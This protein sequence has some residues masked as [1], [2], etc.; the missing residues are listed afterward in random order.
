MVERRFLRELDS[1]PSVHDFVRDF[2]R[3]RGVDDDRA[4][5]VD[6]VIEE[7]FTNL[8][9]HQR[10]REEIGLGLDG[11]SGWVT[12]TLTD[13]DVER[14]DPTTLPDD[15]ERRNRAL[16]PGGRGIGLVKKLVDELRYDYRD[17]T[18]TITATKR[19]SR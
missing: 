19:W 5:E 10:G 2:C 16:I 7:L 3:A 8:V 11:E 9:K 17:R 13:R 18:G 14:F 4:F 6:L 15:T 12:I 1:L